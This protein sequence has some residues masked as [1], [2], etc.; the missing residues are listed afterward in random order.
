MEVHTRMVQAERM[1]V[2]LSARAGDV[3]AFHRIVAAHHE[4]MRR[5][6][7]FVAG[8]L[9]LAEEATQ[10]AWIVAWR[11]LRDVREPSHLRPWLVTVAANEAKQL[12]R[13]RRARAR[14][15][16]AI[17]PADEPGGLDPATGVSGLD[18]RRA[19]SRLDP[20]DRALLA[21]RYV[22]GFDASELATAI[23]KSP[24]ATRQ[25]LKRLL[26]RLREDLRD[27]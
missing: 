15:E 17:E 25:R 16:L 7:V 13:K 10:A 9:S 11:R 14:F 1:D 19:M 21:M 8:D 24:A 12:L 23:G 6:C 2:L 3:A 5:V 26:D 4:D 27:G 22:A 18:L 20:D